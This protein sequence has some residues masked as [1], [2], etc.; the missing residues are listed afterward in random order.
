LRRGMHSRASQRHCAR[1]QEHHGR[2]LSHGTALDTLVQAEASGV[3]VR[4]ILER[5]PKPYPG[6]TTP[7]NS[8]RVDPNFS[9]DRP[10][11]MVIDKKQVITVFFR[12]TTNR[13]RR[14]ASIFVI[15]GRDLARAYMGS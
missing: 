5:A 3:N 2:S 14:V 12:P 6:S 1:P 10:E 11:L 13:R 8:Q 4:T 7:Q 9:V 15:R